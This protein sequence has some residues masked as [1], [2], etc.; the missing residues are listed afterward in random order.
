MPNT[1]RGNA[2]TAPA[3][4]PP[5]SRLRGVQMPALLAL[6]VGVLLSAAV[7]AWLLALEQERA[8]TQ[9]ERAARDRFLSL[10]LELEQSLN[11]LQGLS[12]YMRATP[13]VGDEAF[14]AVARPLLALSPALQ[15]LVWAPRAEGAERFPVLRVYPADGAPFAAGSDP[16]ANPAVAAAIRT[17][18]DTARV[19]LSEAV[20]GPNDTQARVPV[21]VMPVYRNLAA[22]AE[23]KR[24]A[25]EFA[26]VAL[27][28]LDPRRLVE[29]AQAR[30][31]PAKVELR[32]FDLSAPKGRQLLYHPLVENL[33]APLA[34]YLAEPD[35]L[36]G[37]ERLSQQL[38]LGQRR[39]LLVATPVAGQFLAQSGWR[40]WWG[41]AIGLA[42]TL[43]LAF[44]LHG[45]VGRSA[46]VEAM[47]ARRGAELAESERRLRQIVE[48]SPDVH[49]V[50]T[51]DGA[52]LLYV[53]PAFERVWGYA[54]EAAFARP[55]LRR[56]SIYPDD[57]EPLRRAFRA[58][59]Q[60]GGYELEYRIVRAD[61]EVRW[62]RERA[63]A[64]RG[65]GDE[66]YRIAGV[67]EDISQR[68][69][70]DV[71]LVDS[72]ARLRAL[73]E[74]AGDGIITVDEAGAIESFNATAE[75]QFGLLAAEVLGRPLVERIPGFDPH[76]APEHGRQWEGVRGSG[77]RFPVV[78]SVGDMEGRS[79]RCYVCIVHD[80]TALQQAAA[81]GL[82]ER[83]RAQAI[84]VSL[85]AAVVTTDPYGRVDYLS[86]RAAELIGRDAAE[87]LGRTLP[88]VVPLR[89]LRTGRELEDLTVRAG[90]RSGGC[91]LVR[92]DGAT[93]PVSYTLTPVRVPGTLIGGV[94][95]T[96]RE[97]AAA[98]A[99]GATDGAV[100]AAVLDRPG[101]V[102][103]LERALGD[104]RLDG[105]VHTLIYLKLRQLGVVAATDGA[106]AVE[107]VLAELG[108]RLRAALPAGGALGRVGSDE[109]AV[110]CE[111]RALAA[112]EL[113]LPVLRHAVEEHRVTVQGHHRLSLK[114]DLG[115]IALDRDC[116]GALEALAAADLACHRARAARGKVS[117]AATG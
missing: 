35:N 60:T 88:E 76:R 117:D 42:L 69:A 78:V 83:D 96:L 25:G 27:A 23:E 41:L 113:L 13:N 47:V 85:E 58:V 61:G 89:D 44:Y 97:G 4:N 2:R 110:L 46:Q 49:W 65:P 56:E 24:R 40:P 10:A 103:R 98:E 80:L 102:A 68:R 50:C 115:A 106:E 112:A 52:L 71:G 79:G 70:A 107:R 55:S 81:A 19:V 5:P 93:V 31:D 100:A 15:S 36:G 84:V 74:A 14:A 73:V 17:A 87:A 54:V 26:G 51:V 48:P 67:A 114:A 92:S 90:G 22:F 12:A 18:R 66:V 6:V 32:L 39:W 108:E 11:A 91:V 105:R 28:T 104:S 99:D 75:R 20:A 63:H 82:R 30:L 101:F 94:V 111:G 9:F 1:P 43:A 59:A 77:Q 62:I 57:R 21:A 8:Q 37:I 7:C 33:G 109:F 45:V 16:A 53:S 72:E 86:P 38:E 116:G 3:P 29:A 34:G 95:L 64:V